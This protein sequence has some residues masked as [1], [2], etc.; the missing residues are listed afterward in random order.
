MCFLFMNADAQ[1]KIDYYDISEL[2]LKSGEL[3]AEGKLD[4]LMTLLNS[5]NQNDSLYA[6]I[7]VTKSYYLLQNEKFEQA[8]DTINKGLQL[9]GHNSYS[10][11]FINKS[12]VLRNLER[13][14]DAL[15]AIDE[16]LSS[17]P[18]YASLISAR[19]IIELQKNDYNSALQSFEEAISL[20]PF[21]TD[22]HLYLGDFYYKNG[23][24]AQA[25]LSYTMYLILSPDGEQSGKILSMLDYTFARNNPN[26]YNE[27]IDL[28][29]ND[30]AFEE[31]NLMVDNMVAN[32]DKYEYDHPIDIAFSR[33]L[34]L[35]LEMLPNVSLDG[36]LWK[37]KY[38]K[39][40]N[41]IIDNN[42][43]SDLT[44]LISF[45]IENE[46][47][48]K[49][50]AKKTEDISEF[51]AKLYTKWMDIA[52]ENEVVYQGKKQNVT[53][54]YDEQ[55]FD[56]MGLSDG[57][58]PI[59]NWEYYF[60]EGN[61]LSKGL[62]TNE[63]LRDGEWIWYHYN[64]N[65]KEKVQ[66]KDGKLEGPYE[67]YLDNGNLESSFAYK[68][69]AL[70]GTYK[71]Y[72]KYGALI[73]EKQFTNGML[74]GPF[75]TFY[76]TAD[77]QVNF[78]Y[79]FIAGEVNGPVKYFNVD[80]QANFEGNA[81][82]G[83][84]IGK[85]TNYYPNGAVEYE[86]TFVDGKLDGPFVGYFA[87]GNKYEEGNMLQDLRDG[88][89]KSYY[90]DGKM[91]I[92]T[93]YKE[94]KIHGLQTEVY[95][96]GEKF[97]VFEYKNDLLQKYTFYTRD[98]KILHE[99]KKKSGNFQY[100]GFDQSG[101][102]TS[103]GLYD[104]KGGKE[105][106]WKY[107]YAN[108][109]LS[110]EE[111]YAKGALNGT[112]TNYYIN[113]KISDKSEYVNDT[114]SGYFVA[115]HENGKMSLQG[116]YHKGNQ[117]QEWRGYYKN[118]SLQKTY[119]SQNGK[120]HGLQKDYS[121]EG[122][123]SS[124][125]FYKSDEIIYILNYDHNGAKVDSFNF[126]TMKERTM[127]YPNG[128]VYVKSSYLNGNRNGPYAAYN[129]DGSLIFEGEFLNDNQHGTWN[130]YHDNGNLK[131]NL[132]YLQGLKEGEFLSYHDNGKLSDK[133]PFLNNINDGVHISY[134]EDGETVSIKTDFVNDLLHGRKTFY[135]Q[136]GELQ[137][138]RFYENGILLGYTYLDEN[139]KEKD[140]IPIVNQTGDIESYYKNGT[141]ARKFTVVAGKFDGEYLTYYSNGKL[142][143]QSFYELG[144]KK[145]TEKS[146]Y[147]DGT[148]KSEKS[149]EC[150]DLNGK[151]IE[152]YS[153]GKPKK[154]LYY[155]NDD[156]SGEAKY[157]NEN[158]ELSKTKTFFNGVAIDEQK[159]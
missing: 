1:N 3:Q 43:Q 146:Y 105:G 21:D 90:P 54:S 26:K 55:V 122:R 93:T 4:E 24:I 71:G 72:N 59:G 133:D 110:S 94:G 124:K 57:I 10:N 84:I 73:E 139:G 64:G 80:G 29:K 37:N 13:Y 20:S 34:S 138:T 46:K 53:Y 16:G 5:V 76:S 60:P 158:G 81:V 125:S 45:S 50:V 157:Y 67:I 44:Y 85:G 42:Y 115:Y 36:N 49:T 143:E 77:K 33:Q 106:K 14:D 70:D 23:R 118:G 100:K 127:L 83:S 147:L 148:L 22:S 52:A 82:A 103:E 114:L 123:L 92:E 128:E 132:K 17:Y 151:Y 152:Y 9:S 129:I 155:L 27:E 28:G 31:L 63:G 117:A 136:T 69:D 112:A 74:D 89:W 78:D 140:M 99:A 40:Y 142:E 6:D 97:N 154:E 134:H 39:L 2:Y 156:L 48:A 88:L 108:G 11:F 109:Q 61:L 25:L 116:N 19:G 51:A 144:I 141:L 65:V 15:A 120:I 62:Y 41:W 101:N 135:D 121:V 149:Y 119:F 91:H 35:A 111:N 56:G 30:I 12:V 102:L 7:L 96:T 159:K 75:K 150:N 58:N 66:F 87:N 8:L 113:G 145:G 79:S 153:N 131:W 38:G 137:I 47:M 104:I 107:Y 98:G 68:N 95:P 86:K 126:E 130:Y 32:D 18:K